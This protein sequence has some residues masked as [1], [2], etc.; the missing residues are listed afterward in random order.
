MKKKL[1]IILALA[2][3]P[4]LLFGASSAFGSSAEEAVS[5][6]A[7]SL[8][9]APDGAESEPEYINPNGETDRV[10]LRV[11]GHC[12][13]PHAVALSEIVNRVRTENGL[14]PFTTD[15]ALNTAA[16]QRAA[17]SMLRFEHIRPDGSEPKTLDPRI[18]A[19]LLSVNT[20]PN[21]SV[22][23]WTDE[24]S[25]L[26]SILLEPLY[27]TAGY[28]AVRSGDRIFYVLLL[29]TSPAEEGEWPAEADTVYQVDVDTDIL[30]PD[31]F[32]MQNLIDT[33][34]AG[35][36]VQQSLT[37]TN[38]AWPSL[39]FTLD[40]EDLAWAS[41]NPEIA[42]VD[43]NGVVQAVAPGAFRIRA[44]LK[45]HPGVYAEWEGEVI[46]PAQKIYRITNGSETMDITDTGEFKLLYHDGWRL[47][48]VITP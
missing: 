16:M 39:G 45:A 19:E 5:E 3:V 32:E 22:R 15:A 40:R 26:R 38:A 8:I 31:R 35:R 1:S 36:F 24:T 37:L 12:F 4:A 18:E 21:F 34:E 9:A 46:S 11:P 47:S 28:G 13:T 6:E 48:E 23:D 27:T 42:Q 7:P 33:V 43:K 10:T 20:D 30:R 2:L 25:P 29:T 44:M 41:H 17:E 14:A